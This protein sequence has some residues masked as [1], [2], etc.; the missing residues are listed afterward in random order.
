[1]PR[2][3]LGFLCVEFTLV[4]SPLFLLPEFDVCRFETKSTPL[5]GFC[6]GCFF[7]LAFALLEVF[8]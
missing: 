6:D 2:F 8:F 4:E 3:L 1:M 5:F 7:E